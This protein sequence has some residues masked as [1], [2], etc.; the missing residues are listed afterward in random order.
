MGFCGIAQPNYSA[1]E[2]LESP[3]RTWFEVKLRQ[4]LLIV[5]FGSV[6]SVA[7]VNAQQ[8]ESSS[9]GASQNST[10]LACYAD[11]KMISITEDGKTVKIPQV[12]VQFTSPNS[13][14]SSFGCAGQQLELNVP[15]GQ[16]VELITDYGDAKCASKFTNISVSKAST[17]SPIPDILSLALK[18]GAF[19]IE[20]PPMYEIPPQSNR[21]VQIDATCKL[22][23]DR[24]YTQSIKITYQNP[25]RVIVTA[26]LV[27]A[28]GVESYGLNSSVTGSG[29]GGTV[30]TQNM[31]A[32][33]GSPAQEVI[34]FGFANIYYFSSHKITL[35]AQLGVGANPNLSS[36]KPEVF[37]S[38][39]SI[40]W[41]NFYVSP[42]FHIG[43]HEDIGG[44]FALGDITPSGFS[45]LPLKWSL[46]TG[47]GVSFSYNVKPS[48]K[49]SSTAG[50]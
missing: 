32:V 18:G 14:L 33:T 25:P 17:D 2:S 48:S 38:P 29:A 24:K 5:L 16:R 44:G 40:G 35:N 39:V 1:L 13:T 9:P 41:H 45:K 46:Y 7:T 21:I 30:T 26:G 6:T 10:I 27:L 49:G 8:P 36:A 37:A 43:Q 31:V 12:R 3:S 50:K 11:K 47:F 42:G 22:D 15:N 28:H 20:A 34:P 4:S 23:G 19:G